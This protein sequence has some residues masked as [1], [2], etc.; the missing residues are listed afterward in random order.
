MQRARVTGVL[1]LSGVLWAAGCCYKE[2]SYGYTRE[3][4]IGKIGCQTFLGNNVCPAPCDTPGPIGQE[5]RAAAPRQLSEQRALPRA[6]NS[7]AAKEQSQPASASEA[8]A[9]RAASAANAKQENTSHGLL[10]WY[11]RP[12]RLAKPVPATA[13][14]P[15]RRPS[16]VN[17]KHEGT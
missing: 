10:G 13:A 6:G 3:V 15:A 4:R 11:L 5:E 14:E 16:L 1:F 12:G 2:E 7:V 17:V 9:P 8:D